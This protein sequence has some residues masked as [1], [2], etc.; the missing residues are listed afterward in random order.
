MN[1]TNTRVPPEVQSRANL[2][3]NLKYYR[4]KRGQSISTVAEKLGMAP[5][6]YG[7]YETGSKDLEVHWLP[8]VST[9][10]GVPLNALLAP[11]A[12][13]DAEDYG[14]TDQERQNAFAVRLT[15]WRILH[16][17]SRSALGRQAEVSTSIIDHFERGERAPTLEQAQGI[18][19]V[20]ETT[21]L[22]LLGKALF[23]K[24]K[25]G[26]KS[27]AAPPPTTGKPTDLVGYAQLARG[28]GYQVELHKGNVVSIAGCAR[29]EMSSGEF[30]SMMELAKRTAGVVI[31]GMLSR[32]VKRV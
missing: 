31:T 16:G 11:T 12:A 15:R 21:P 22:E 26:G 7:H 29:Y 6:D 32:Q 20:L 25:G 23:E 24:V 9:A 2:V 17:L 8:Q 28:Y 27:V 4:F 3:A 19:K 10:L 14:A 5:V 30:V 18:A 1:E 13:R